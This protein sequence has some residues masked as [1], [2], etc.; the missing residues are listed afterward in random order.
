MAQG[1]R[2]HLPVIHTMSVITSL[3]GNMNRCTPVFIAA[4]FIIAKTW[5]QPKCSLMHTM[6]YY[7][8]IKIMN[9]AI[10]SNTDATRDYHVK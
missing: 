8:A 2:I 6:E 10:C 7:A 5:K 4:L 9:D 3:G 1:I